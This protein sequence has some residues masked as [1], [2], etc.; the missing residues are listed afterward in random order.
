METEDDTELVAVLSLVDGALSPLWV[1][2][3]LDVDVGEFFLPEVSNWPPSV[4][5]SGSQASTNVSSSDDGNPEPIIADSG[6]TTAVRDAHEDQ[7]GKAGVGMELGVREDAKTR[8]TEELVLPE[9]KTERKR[10]QKRPTNYKPNKARDEQRKELKELRARSMELEQ[11]LSM[12]KKLR[13]FPNAREGDKLTTWNRRVVT[14]PVAASVWKSI[15]KR[16]FDKL[17]ATV[18]ENKELKAQ[19]GAGQSMIQRVEKLLRSHNLEKV[20]ETFLEESFELNA[21]VCFSYNRQHN[22]RALS[23]PI[24]LCSYHDFSWTLQWSKDLKLGWRTATTRCRSFSRAFMATLVELPASAALN[25]TQTLAEICSRVCSAPRFSRMIS[26]RL[27]KLPGLSSP[28]PFAPTHAVSSMRSC[29]QQ[30]TWLSAASPPSCTWTAPRWWFS[31]GKLS[32]GISKQGGKLSCGSRRWTRSSF[33]GK[34]SQAQ[35][36]KS[37]ASS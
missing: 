13:P 24:T 5:F 37:T 19:V 15:A 7:D 36:T 20:T 34:K 2:D 21:D 32:G 17:T 28:S 8:K 25:C 35:L 11:H 10:K 1:G 18:H 12:L 33:E 27:V 31:G 30:M 9:V 16:Q 14:A 29:T 23:N 3:E 4:D 6:T 22:L 26:A